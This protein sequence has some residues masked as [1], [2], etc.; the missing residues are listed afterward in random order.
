MIDRGL[1]GTARQAVFCGGVLPVLDDIEVKTTHLGTTEVVDLLVDQ[2]ELITLVGVLNLLLQLP[3]TIHCPAIKLDHL[4]RCNTIGDRIEAV[5][6]GQQETVGI[7]DAAIGIRSALEDLI[8]DRHLTTVIG[9]RHPQPDDIGTEEI[10]HLLRTNHIAERFRHLVALGIDGET[11]GQ[12]PGI[13][14]TVVDRHRREQG[15]LEPTAV[16]VGPL[17]IEIRRE[18]QRFTLPEYGV[19][20]HTGVKPDIQ[21]VAHLFI[22]LC[23]IT[24]QLIRLQG[25]PGLDPLLLDPL[26]HLLDQPRRLRV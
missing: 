25:E 6:I 17:K 24:Q 5:E 19:V 4:L 26:R 8:G 3:C 9:G 18:T 16:L 7:A 1:T 14:R 11:V 21:G 22:L 10:H 20:G 12:H 13:R 2:V 23:L 15:R